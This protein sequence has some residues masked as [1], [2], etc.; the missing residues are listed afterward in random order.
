MTLDI[1]KPFESYVAEDELPRTGDAR[2]FAFTLPYEVEGTHFVAKISRE[3]KYSGTQEAIQGERGLEELRKSE[4]QAFKQ[5]V[6]RELRES[7]E[8]LYAQGDRPFL[9]RGRAESME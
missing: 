5:Q 8:R 4:M 7:R 3:W 9:V 6:A 2:N 1:T